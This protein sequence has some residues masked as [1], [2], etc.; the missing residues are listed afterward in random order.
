[1]RVLESDEKKN[2]ASEMRG[3]ELQ[4]ALCPAVLLILARADA[5]APYVHS[6][7]AASA[8]PAFANVGAAARAFA[9]A[10]ASATT[11]KIISQAG[12]RRPPPAARMQEQGS[13]RPGGDIRTPA[14]RIDA[15]GQPMQVRWCMI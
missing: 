8:A 6:H 5:D 2:S 15:M 4:W 14:E 11:K 9:A 1:L 13:P 3:F 12:R 10:A 7:Q